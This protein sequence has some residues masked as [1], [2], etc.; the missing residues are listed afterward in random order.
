MEM[1]RKNHSHKDL[2]LDKITLNG[3][4][5]IPNRLDSKL[6]GY[7]RKKRRGVYG[8]YVPSSEKYVAKNRF[9]IG[10]IKKSYIGQK[11]T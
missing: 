9:Y 8:V 5:V 1:E 4:G 7:W 10:K 11:K 6:Q 2:I 3:L